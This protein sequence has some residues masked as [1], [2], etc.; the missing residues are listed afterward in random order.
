[1]THFYN[2]VFVDS[3]QGLEKRVELYLQISSTSWTLNQNTQGTFHIW[4]NKFNQAFPPK[5]LFLSGQKMSF[6]WKKK[7][8]LSNWPRLILC[9]DGPKTVFSVTT[10]INKSI[11][12]ILC[13]D[14]LILQAKSL[15]NETKVGLY[16]SNQEGLDA[17]RNKVKARPKIGGYQQWKEIKTLGNILRDSTGEC[18]KIRNT[19]LQRK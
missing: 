14:I 1:M 9:Q 11:F 6:C 13:H 2:R 12:I 15:P 4:L 16:Y 18:D 5:S 7:P 17:G 10:T 3:F 8:L 19:Q